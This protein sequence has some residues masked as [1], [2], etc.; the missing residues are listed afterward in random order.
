L[1]DLERGAPAHEQDILGQRHVTG[2]QLR[3]DHLVNGVVTADVFC[4][5]D[6]P[7]GSIEEPSG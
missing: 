3:A 7:S 1:K 6:E 2:E 4:D 5:P